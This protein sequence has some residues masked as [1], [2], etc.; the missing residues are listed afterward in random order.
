MK[1]DLLIDSPISGTLIS[2]ADIR[3]KIFSRGAAGC[4][5]AIKN[6]D[7]KIVAPF[8]G[9]IKFFASPGVLGLTSF[10]GVELLIHVGLNTCKF[11][12]ESFRPQVQVGDTIA[13]GQI[14][15][16]FDPAEVERAGFD[17]TTPVVVT[18]PEN[19]G[20][21]VFCFGERKFVAKSP[22]ARTRQVESIGLNFAPSI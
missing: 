2:L 19:F 12:G 9:T 5:I 10:G 16:T 17:T 18:N 7:G 8:D 14:L 22:V 13:R 4:G 3:D 1:Q 11:V 20:E 21:I 6:P 15:L